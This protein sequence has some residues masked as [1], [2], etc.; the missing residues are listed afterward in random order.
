MKHEKIAVLLGGSSHEREVSLVSGARVLAALQGAGFTNATAVDPKELNLDTLRA[1]DRAFIALHGRHGEDGTMQGVLELLN[2]PYTGSGVMA[3]ALAMD[4]WRTKLVWQALGLPIPDYV[5]ID[6]TSDFLA[7]EKRLGL[8]LSP[9]FVKP[10]SEG[11]SIGITKVTCSGGL[12][13]AYQEAR[14]YDS[15]VMAEQA[16][17]GGEYTVA[18]LAN[19]NDIEALPIIR[20][21]PATDFY[22]YEAKYSRDDTLYHCP[23]GL[24]AA[25]EKELQALAIAAFRALG[26]R[27]WAR[28]DFLMDKQGNAYLLEANTSP[29]MTDHSLMP[30]AAKAAGIS[31]EQL[32]VRILE[33]ASLG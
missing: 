7:I 16:I 25:R 23:C 32:V 2:L 12:F 31:Y 17:L 15:L 30:M 29:G 18:I 6:E 24:S 26:C 28:I 19:E 22:D 14:Q 1:F 13:A 9:I 3:S 27:G 20:I 5:M 11:S 33:K 10:A 8:P 4:K 21:Q